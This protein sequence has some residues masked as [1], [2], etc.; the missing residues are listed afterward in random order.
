MEHLVPEMELRQ[1]ASD[2]ARDSP[3]AAIKTDVATIVAEP[4]I[5]T[6]NDLGVET[7]WPV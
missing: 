2:E 3:Q 5:S 1:V 7:I 4:Q 6:A